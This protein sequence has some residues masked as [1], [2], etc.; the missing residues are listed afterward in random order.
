M[1]H[2]LARLLSQ[3]CQFHIS[4]GRT[5]QRVE[6]PKS[7]STQLR[8][9]R[10][11]VTLYMMLMSCTHRVAVLILPVDVG[12]LLD[13]LLG[14]LEVPVQHSRHQVLAEHAAQVVV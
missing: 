9:A 8:S 4:P 5:R 11:W 12:A 7:K 13:E 1:F 14:V 3:F 2:H 10:R 6:Q